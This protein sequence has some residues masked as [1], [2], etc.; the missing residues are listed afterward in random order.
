MDPDEVAA[1]VR[2]AAAGD[3]LAWRWLV[4]HYTG[5]VWSVARSFRL[6]KFDAEDV[7]Q[8]TWERCARNLAEIREPEHLG[9]WLATTA[10]REALRVYELRRRTSAGGDLSWAEIDRADSLSPEQVVLDRSEA[11]DRTAFGRRAWLAMEQLPDM[12]RQLLRVLLSTP[13]PTYAE[14][15]AALGRPIGYIGPSRRRC[16]DRLR[17]LLGPPVSA[18]GPAAHD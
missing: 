16:L 7:V 14:A 17:T 3:S 6:E 8:T 5:L 4:D 9:A 11:D 15:A 13:P 1:A 2:A 12:C 10:R 18:D